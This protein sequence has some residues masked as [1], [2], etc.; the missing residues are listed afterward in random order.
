MYPILYLIFPGTARYAL[1]L[2]SPPFRGRYK[3]Q[4]QIAVYFKITARSQE[5]YP[6]PPAAS[7]L[8]A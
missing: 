8:P 4:V 7:R 1:Y 5:K 3:V 6:K 2:I